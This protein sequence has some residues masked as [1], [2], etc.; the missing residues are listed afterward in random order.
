MLRTVTFDDA[1]EGYRLQTL[2]ADAKACGT[3]EVGLKAD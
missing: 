2:A 3:H 1:L